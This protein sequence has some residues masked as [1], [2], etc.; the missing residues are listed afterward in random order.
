MP[1]P[2]LVQLIGIIVVTYVMVRSYVVSSMAFE[3]G[4]L[5]LGAAIFV[6]GKLLEGRERG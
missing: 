1:L 5:A 4:G 3:F 2:R 6:V